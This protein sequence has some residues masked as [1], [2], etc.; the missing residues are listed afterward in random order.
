MKI[1]S[2]Q[3][4]NE[5]NSLKDPEKAQILQRFF[6]TGKGQ[7]AEGDIFWGITVPKQRSIAQKYKL[8]ELSEVKKLVK[9]PIHEIRLTG[10]LLLTYQYLLVSDERKKEIFEFLGY[11][12]LNPEDRIQ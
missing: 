8:L 1:K 2:S 9:S 5:L 11:E 7:Y 6:K 12:Y 3:I 4:I 10:F